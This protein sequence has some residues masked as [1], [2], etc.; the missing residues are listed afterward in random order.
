MQQT[1]SNEGVK[2]SKA[3]FGRGPHARL[4]TK[5]L[6]GARSPSWLGANPVSS[7]SLAPCMVAHQ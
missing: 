7:H 1:I 3:G 2:K 4:L 6:F 5:S